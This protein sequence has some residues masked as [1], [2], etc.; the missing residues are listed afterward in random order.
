[1]FTFAAAGH[2]GKEGS[3]LKGHTVCETWVRLPITVLRRYT[4]GVC[5]VTGGVGGA[6]MRGIRMVYS[7]VCLATMVGSDTPGAVGGMRRRGMCVVVVVVDGG[8]GGS[9]DVGRDQGCE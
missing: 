7:A 2:Y 3:I 8:G 4:R 9:V 1:M 6:A 5:E